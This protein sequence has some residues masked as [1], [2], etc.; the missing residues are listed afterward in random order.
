MEGAHE[1]AWT[2]HEANV[3]KPVRSKTMTQEY[4]LPI[5]D[6][7]A[8]LETMGGKG[9]SLARLLRAGVSQKNSSFVVASD[10]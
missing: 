3:D 7:R 4:V 9:A 2:N 6:Q 8:T 5:D 10:H 1:L